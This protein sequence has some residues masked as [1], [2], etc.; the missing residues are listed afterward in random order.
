MWKDLFEEN[1]KAG[2][3]LFVRYVLS[4]FIDLFVQK[5]EGKENIP[6]GCFIVASNHIDG[7]DHWFVGNLFANRI[8]E[9]YF[10]G[11]MEKLKIVLLFGPIYWAADA[12]RINRKKQDRKE[13]LQKVA[14][15][16][17]KNNIVI[18]YPEGDIN[19]GNK[20]SEGK[21]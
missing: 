6:Q 11:A 21:T 12:I 2:F 1:M 18:I 19:R 9:V 3:N 15:Y 8:E 10:L 16:L 4:P 17:K 20:L 5:V 14:E 13:I 7:W